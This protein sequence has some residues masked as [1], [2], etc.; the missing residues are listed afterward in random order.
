MATQ[1][2]REV[3]IYAA[4]LSPKVSKIKDAAVY[5]AVRVP[6]AIQI[7]ALSA[8]VMSA[9]VQPQAI[10]AV[11]GNVMEAVRPRDFS[12]DPTVAVL[13][14]VNREFTLSLVAGTVSVT[15]RSLAGDAFFDAEAVLTALPGSGL[16][17]SVAVRYR[18]YPFALAFQGKDTS[19]F[20]V[21]AAT[22]IHALLPQINSQY[23]LAL[24]TADVRDGAVPLHGQVTL[25]TLATSIYF[26]PNEQ[27]VLGGIAPSLDTALTVGDLTGFNA[28]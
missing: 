12:I 14:A 27:I 3:G 22:T 28:A 23:N 1:K 20:V 9:N 5:A 4:S 6:S 21:G 7:R 26:R 11:N 17:G 25:L 13:S 19:A 15:G 2:I 18:R 24:T 8:L 10:R 16:K